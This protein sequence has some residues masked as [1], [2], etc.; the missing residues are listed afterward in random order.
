MIAPRSNEASEADLGIVPPH[1]HGD[2]FAGK[3]RRAETRRD[4]AQGARQAWIDGSDNGVTRITEAAQPMQDRPVKAAFA[5]CP[6]VDMQRI[7]I[8]VQAIKQSGVVRDVDIDFKIRRSLR[9]FRQGFGR[10]SRRTAPTVAAAR[11]RLDD[12]RDWLIIVH[13]CDQALEADEHPFLNAAVDH[14][15]DARA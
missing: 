2:R 12:R 14:R 7:E 11:I 13:G 10:R 3:D 9:D 15:Q 6:R 5:G 8:A 4:G 1:L